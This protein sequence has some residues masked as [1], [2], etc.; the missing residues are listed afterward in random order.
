MSAFRSVSTIAAHDHACLLHAS[1]DE[2]WDVAA[3]YV[4]AGLRAGERV[5]YVPDAETPETVVDALALAGSERARREAGGQF[6]VMA[7]DDVYA[8]VD[9]DPER[10][11]LQWGELTQ[12]ALAEGFRGMRVVADM[13]WALHVEMDAQELFVY[14]RA[15]GALFAQLPFSAVCLYDERR[16]SG[17]QI[18]G[19]AQ[20]HPVAMCGG[21]HHHAV[22][23]IADELEL[24]FTASDR[25]RVAGSVDLATIERFADVLRLAG[26]S[27]CDLTLDLGELAFLD[28]R[29]LAT[30]YA[31]A[32]S[33][34]PRGC[35]LLLDATPPVVARL[36]A[37]F[38]DR[39]A[40]AP[41]VVGERGE[42]G[43]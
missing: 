14:E 30:L 20:A 5:V 32:G 6:T 7:Q 23:R 1:D 11:A 39:G 36:L 8:A 37:L 38:G 12:A 18:L 34:A 19:A 41:R 29:G 2:R 21:W 35:E 16:W 33:L 42:E 24:S 43:P 15:A 28:V 9:Y 31:T 3:A 17:E 10:L 25:L 40:P 26:E 22:A 4:D 27:P 13:G